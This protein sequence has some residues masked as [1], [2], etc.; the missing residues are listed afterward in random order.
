MPLILEAGGRGV[1]GMLSGWEEPR[2][3]LLDVVETED[4]ALESA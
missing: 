3:G 2:G 1:F 4:G